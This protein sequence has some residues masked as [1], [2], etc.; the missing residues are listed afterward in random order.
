MGVRSSCIVCFTTSAR[1]GGV[2]RSYTA[3]PRSPV[4]ALRVEGAARKA[5]ATL[6]HARA[7]ARFFGGDI[8]RPADGG[9]GTPVTFVL[10]GISAQGVVSE[11]GP[12]QV[13]NLGPGDGQSTVSTPTG[14]VASVDVNAS[15]GRHFAVTGQS[16]AGGMRFE[17]TP[18]IE[19][20]FVLGLAALPE[21][22]NVQGARGSRK[23]RDDDS[24]RPY[25][26]W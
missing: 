17:L 25:C 18:A 14:T 20:A 6:D 13:N 16:I 8:S 21:W 1:P 11:T 4:L 10:S 7:E 22:K 15:L 5:T 19:T 12:L 9:V 23:A 26:L 24:A 2:E 3:A